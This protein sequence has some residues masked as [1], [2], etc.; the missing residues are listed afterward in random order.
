MGTFPPCT[1]VHQPFPYQLPTHDH[2][3]DTIK[4]SASGVDVPTLSTPDRESPSAAFLEFGKQ[5]TEA[6]RAERATFEQ[7]ES[8]KRNKLHTEARSGEVLQDAQIEH[9]DQ[10]LAESEEA[11][12]RGRIQYE[13]L[14]RRLE[15]LIKSLAVKSAVNARL[16]DE[17][18]GVFEQ[19]EHAQVRLKV[20]NTRTLDL[21]EANEELE[22]LRAKAEH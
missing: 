8:R 7:E 1:P 4:P 2:M 15:D 10:K 20:V 22:V 6:Y 17:K 9:V 21:A 19:H 18:A 11:R 3:D 16:V 13:S 12:E 5:I 14:E